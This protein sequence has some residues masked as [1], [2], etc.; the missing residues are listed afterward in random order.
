MKRICMNLIIGIFFVAAALGSAHTS[1]KVYQLK[2]ADSFPIKHPFNKVVNHFMDAAKKESNGRLDFQY[3]PAQQLGKLHDMLKIAQK[4]LA[5]ITY[6]GPTFFPGQLG[7][8]TVAT[9]PFYDSAK[10]GTV[11]YTELYKQS[12]EI[13]NEWTGNRVRPLLFAA[14]SQYQVGIGD[15]TITSIDDLKGLRLKTPGGV[16]D[17][18]AKRY[19]IV[20]VAMSFNDAYESVQKGIIDGAI[21][22]LPSVKGYRLYEVE[23]QQTIGLRLGAYVTTYAMNEK[24]FK[25]LPQDLQQALIKAGESASVFAADLWDDMVAGL[26]KQ[27]EG[28]GLMAFYRISGDK[29]AEWLAPLRG[30]EEEWIKEYEAKGLPARKVFETFNDIA[31]KVTAE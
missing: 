23:K 8:N 5:D 20:P 26:E 28:D 18:M 30:I 6:V 10:Q 9:L 12:A 4:G 7:L 17:N 22:T 3:F 25:K 27:F 21:H 15:K 24:K 11:I 16:F 31:E 13:R 1:D 29:K 14:T 19:G 2:I